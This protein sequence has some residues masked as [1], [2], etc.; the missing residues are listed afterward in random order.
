LFEAREEGNYKPFV[1]F[2]KEQVEEWIRLTEEFIEK[3]EELIRNT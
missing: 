1:S 3:M 2:E